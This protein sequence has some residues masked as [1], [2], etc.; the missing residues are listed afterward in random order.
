MRGR[1]E[2]FGLYG[3][4]RNLEVSIRNKGLK[5]RRESKGGEYVIKCYKELEERNK[6]KQVIDKWGK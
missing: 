1:L 5:I 6:D 4:R 2:T 3:K